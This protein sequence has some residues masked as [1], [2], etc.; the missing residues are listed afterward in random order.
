MSVFIAKKIK[1]KWKLVNK[2]YNFAEAGSYETP[3]DK[4]SIKVFNINNK[5]MITIDAG[6]GNMGYMY[7][8]LF[9]YYPLNNKYK[10][11]GNIQ[12]SFDNS[13]AVT[14]K[15]EYWYGKYSFVNDNNSKFP[16]I[17][18]KITGEKGKKNY[19]KEQYYFFNGTKYVMKKK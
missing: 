8:Y 16:G 13:G 14:G 10:E 7:D 5:Y 4:E 17:L 1:N 6:G 18:L 3:P 15:L 9:L 19:T 11:I 2:Y 12:T